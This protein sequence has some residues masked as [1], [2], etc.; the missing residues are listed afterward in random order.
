MI[1]IAVPNQVLAVQKFDYPL[2]VAETKYESRCRDVPPE[3]LYL[4]R[5]FS[6]SD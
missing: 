1:D 2:G 3:R 4:V 5:L 6:P